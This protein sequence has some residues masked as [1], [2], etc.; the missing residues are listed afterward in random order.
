MTIALLFLLGTPIVQIQIVWGNFAC[1]ERFFNLLAEAIINVRNVGLCTG[2][3]IFL[4]KITKVLFLSLGQVVYNFE[5]TPT[6]IQNAIRDVHCPGKYCF[7][8]EKCESVDGYV[9]TPRSIY[10]CGKCE[11]WLFGHKIFFCYKSP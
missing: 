11:A 1:T 5:E 10:G 2:C 7:N 8:R 9:T 6:S 3:A 4:L